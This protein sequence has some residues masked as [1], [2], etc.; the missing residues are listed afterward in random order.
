L[1]LTC[2]LN[3]ALN[4]K[5]NAQIARVVSEAWLA[6]EMY[7]PACSSNSITPAAN[8]CP[9]YDFACP[10]CS[11]RYQLKSRK[12]ALT[13]RIVDAGYKAMIGAIRSEQ[14]PN[15][16]LLQYSPS[17]SVRTLLLIPSFF[18]T[19]SAIEKRKPLSASAERANWVGCNILLGNIPIDG[20][21]AVV[22]DGVAVSPLH[23]RSEYQRIK[24]LS[25]LDRATRGWTLDVLNAV[26]RLGKPE[27]SLAEVYAAE[28]RLQALHPG[29]RNVK[30]KIRQQLQVLR[31]LGFLSFEDNK[32]RYRV[33]R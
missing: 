19:E 30:P 29:N 16:F 7:C 8:N 10:K 31:N 4:Y 12:S 33:V 3:C 17:W 9:G 6:R 1:D 2:S 13:N 18:F 26:R 11:L 24:P 14:A 5:S 28:Q 20:R 32:G 27:F 15:L 21:I 23:I 22:M 25:A